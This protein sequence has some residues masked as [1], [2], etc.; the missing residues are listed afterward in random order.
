M[1]QGILSAIEFLEI[2]KIEISKVFETLEIF[3][4]RFSAVGS[5]IFRISFAL[6]I[7]GK[8]IQ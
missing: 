5:L 1:C 7:I 3:K 6:G 8:N 4:P 2:G